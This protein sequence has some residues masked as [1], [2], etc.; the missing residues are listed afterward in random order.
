[1]SVQKRLCSGPEDFPA[2]SDFLYSLYKPDNRDGNW[3]QPVWEYA[4]THPWFDDDA[5][6][7]IGIW[8]ENNTIVGV[9]MYEL[10]LGEAFFQT[11]PGYEY[12]KPEML[13]HA[14]EHFIRCADDGTR[15]LH[16]FVSD[17][18]TDFEHIVQ[19]RGYT[20]SPKRDRPMARWVLPEQFPETTVPEGFTVKSLAD[21]ND[22]RKTDRVLWRG[23]DHPGEPPEDGVEG[24]KRMQSGPHF[25]LDLTMVAE[26]PNG[27]FVSFAGLWFDAVNNIAYVEPVATD[28]DYRRMGL[29]RAALTEG[30]RRC[31]ELGA[32]VA[33]V[34][35]TLPIYRSMGFELVY[36]SK[37]WRKTF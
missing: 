24:R 18:D 22:L 1:M 25:R 10:A 5:V 28:P 9:T 6:S 30:V 4:Y 16:A 37:C 2:I 26:A 21:E 17:F 33:F 12:L 19:S 36:T 7:H 29:A 34:G 11:A 15:Y 13:N 27:D 14:K 8:E 3:L 31:A 20:E 32:T 23:F 35:A